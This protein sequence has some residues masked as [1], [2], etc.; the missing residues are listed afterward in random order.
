MQLGEIKKVAPRQTA[1]NLHGSEPATAEQAPGRALIAVTPAA[2]LR[3][4]PENYCRAPFLAQLISMKDRHPQ[5]R[6]RRRAEPH[7]ALA[8]YRTAAK[9]ISR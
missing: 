2:A 4:P 7:E 3:A 8:A 6:E 9:L 5:T 1:P